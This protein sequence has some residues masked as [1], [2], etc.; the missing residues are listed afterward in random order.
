MWCMA[1]LNRCDESRRSCYELQ[2]D[3]ISQAHVLVHQDGHAALCNFGLTGLHSLAEKEHSS[4][5]S[6]ALH[7]ATRA[8]FT[9]TE[10][11]GTFRYLAPE[12][13]VDGETEGSGPSLQTDVYAFGCTCAEV[14]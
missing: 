8:G 12:Q 1:Q 7:Y 4:D 10:F 9:E 2:S 14:R 13:I 3:D 5:E 11:G 6:S